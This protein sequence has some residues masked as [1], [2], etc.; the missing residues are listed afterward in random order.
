MFPE[1]SMWAWERTIAS[2]A[3]A[4]KRQAAVPV[5]R[6][7]AGGLRACNRGGSEPFT[8]RTCLNR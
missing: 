2:M 8:E 3:E 1:W 7:S 6:F 4:S 5:E